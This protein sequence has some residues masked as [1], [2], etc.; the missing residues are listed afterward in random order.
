[1]FYATSQ[2][3][4]STTLRQKIKQGPK[5]VQIDLEN[6]RVTCALQ[7]LHA[8]FKADLL[9]GSWLSLPEQLDHSCTEAILC[10]RELGARE[11]TSIMYRRCTVHI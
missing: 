10:A 2:T 9:A 7:G 4:G 6:S 3:L 5:G 11:L 8:V 1:M